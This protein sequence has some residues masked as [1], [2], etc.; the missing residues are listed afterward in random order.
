MIAK[1]N[2]VKLVGENESKKYLKRYSDEADKA[3]E[4]FGARA[5]ELN[6]FSIYLLE[7]VK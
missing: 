2:F 4:I 6:T 5:D 3:L 7:R 1:M